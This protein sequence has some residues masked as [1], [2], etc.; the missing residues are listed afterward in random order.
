MD[1]LE[2]SVL[3]P[4]EG[5][6]QGVAWTLALLPYSATSS[7]HRTWILELWFHLMLDHLMLDGGEST[8]G[9]LN[10]DTQIP[11]LIHRSDSAQ[12]WGG[13]ENMHLW[14]AANDAGPR[15]HWDY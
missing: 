1:R 6:N 10:T 14:K 8:V 2:A 4:T 3:P 7:H 12:A 15:D 13:P 5:K 11:G 9:M